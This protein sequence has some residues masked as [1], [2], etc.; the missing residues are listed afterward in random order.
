[1]TLHLQ[2]T[3][4]AGPDEDGILVFSD[5]GLLAV[6]VRLSEL[7]GEMAGQWFL[8]ATFGELHRSRDGLFRD[9]A[10]AQEWI[11]QRVAGVGK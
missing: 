1:V 5:V 4:L 3:R 11:A 6:L 10:A 9:L 8:E 7:H 2:P